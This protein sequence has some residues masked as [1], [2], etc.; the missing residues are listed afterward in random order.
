VTDLESL[1][2]QTVALGCSDLHLQAG[3]RPRMRLQGELSEVDGSSVIPP[4]DLESLLCGLLD[5]PQRQRLDHQGYLD[6]ALSRGEAR[7]RVHYYRQRT[8]L[9]AAF[10]HLA[11]KPPSLEA[12]RLPPQVAR[13]AHLRQGLVLVTGATGSGKSTTLAAI[14]DLVNRT[15]RRNVVTIEDPIEYLH[16]SA[17]STVEQRAVGRHVPSFHQ[18]VVDS[19]HQDS[20]V[21][22]VGELRDYETVRAALTAAET[23]IL[24]FGTLH[25]NDVAQSIDRILDL[26]SYEEQALVRVMLSHSLQA[27]VSQVLL[28]ERTGKNRVPACEIMFRTPAIAGMI[29]GDKIHEIRNAIQTG[30]AAGMMLLDDSLAALVEQRL[31]TPEE[32]ARFARNPRRFSA[33]RQEWFVGTEVQK[34][35]AETE[36]RHEARVKGLNLVNVTELDEVGLGTELTVGRTIDLS[37]DGVSIQLN[38]Q[39]LIGSHVRLQLALENEVIEVT[40]KVRSSHDL[41][42]GT[43]AVGLL[44]DKL[45]PDDA[46]ALDRYIAVHG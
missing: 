22:V 10:R 1:M 46:R 17:L 30:R 34:K 5:G 15:Y 21:L 33:G 41:H 37:H 42:D 35:A 19:L 6:F 43:Y 3:E 25:S 39:L 24:V 28:D 16:E 38:H 27:V 11:G 31:V 23:G 7:W 20:D 4:G 12:L 14:L 36:R 40:A 13:V 8:G 26:Y 29:R 32:A 44:F 45:P 9:S 18:G 2:S